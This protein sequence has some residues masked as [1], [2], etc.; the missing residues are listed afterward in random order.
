VWQETAVKVKF[1]IND[2]YIFFVYT[3]TYKI[4]QNSSQ[5]YFNQIFDLFY[6]NFMLKKNAAHGSE[7]TESFDIKFDWN[8]LWIILF[9]VSVDFCV[10][11]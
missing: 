5:W 9:Y 10:F 2:S 4:I 6:N 8:V 1:E 3:H 7:A 11:W